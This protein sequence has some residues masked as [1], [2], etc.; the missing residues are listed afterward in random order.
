MELVKQIW[1][2]KTEAQVQT[3]THTPCRFSFLPGVAFLRVMALIAAVC[4]VMQAGITGAQAEGRCLLGRFPCR[5]VFVSTV[6]R[7]L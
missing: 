5:R 6:D 2:S 3:W 4:F 1:V 7:I